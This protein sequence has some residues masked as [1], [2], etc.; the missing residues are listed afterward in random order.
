MSSKRKEY[1]VNDC[2]E[3]A[4]RFF[5]PCK[6]NPATKMKV[7]EA[8]RVRGYSYCKAANLTL[9]MQVGR[10]IQ[11]IKGEVSLCPEAAAAHSLLTLATAAAHAAALHSQEA[12]GHLFT[13]YGETLERVE[14]FKYLG[15]LIAYNDANTQA[16]QLNLRKALGCWAW[17]LHVL[18][19]EN[20]TA[21]L[22]AMFYKA[23]M[24]AVL[25]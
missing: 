5:I 17:I 16:K 19:A 20:A 23:T 9:Q 11:K 6:A 3:K 2:A 1:K 13:V 7:T 22:C 25:L 8:M 14:V 18:R 15:Q 21:R 10:V 4:A 12:L 24:Q